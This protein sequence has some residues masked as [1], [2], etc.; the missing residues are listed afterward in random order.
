[1]TLHS[2][3][4]CPV[5]PFCP[6]LPIR[7][8][9]N[10]CVACLLSGIAAVPT[11]AEAQRQ[12]P[13]LRDQNL[14]T[15]LE[16]KVLCKQ[17]GRYIGW[18]S[19]AQATNGDLLVVFSGD[20]TAH[21]S[22][23][24]KTQMIRS[25]D[26]GRT[27]SEPATIHDFPIDDRDAGIVRTNQG[28]L[29]VSWFTGP[30]YHTELQGHYVIRSTDNGQSWSKP[31][32]T[33][34]TTPHGPVQ[35]ADGRLLFLGQKPHCSHTKPANYNGP[36]RDSPH[37]VAIEESR[38]DGVSWQLIASFPVPEDAKMLSFDEPHLAEATDGKLIAQFR[39]CN[40]PHRLWQSESTDGGRTWSAPWQ[41]PLHGYP[42]HLLHLS[43]DWLLS[44]YAKRWPPFGQYA[45]ASR[46][47][48]RTWDVE[49]E[50]RL[51]AGLN[52]DL[53]YPASVELQDGT[54]WTVYYEIDKAGE[55]PCLMGTHW[56]FKDPAAP[57]GS[58]G[59]ILPPLRSM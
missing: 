6:S 33:Q 29:L 2:C 55:K 36:P 57:N 43:S 28:T 37:A 44:T 27:W 10:A 12:R 42:P 3:P 23:D 22:P 50:I 32:R 31:I 46:D 26:G 14:A 53:G 21:V 40:A 7:L 4:F 49:N 48:G 54:I 41:T 35:L 8:I 39:D 52:G 51:S 17:P 56:R 58:S 45:S 34:V 16:R 38:D 59:G 18:P 30:P 13:E 5:R 19:I 47:N 20:R 1:M 9:C 11:S 24:G 15:V 25:R